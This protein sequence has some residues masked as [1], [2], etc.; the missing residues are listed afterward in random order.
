MK[1]IF[2]TTFAVAL[3]F[4]MTACVEHSIVQ[5]GKQIAFK[6]IPSMTTKAPVNGTTMPNDMPLYVSAYHNDTP[7]GE[8]YFTGV[9]FNHESTGGLWASAVPQYWPIEQNNGN[10]N[11]LAYGTKNAS[12]ITATW[13]ANVASQVVLE[14]GDNHIKR[15]DLLYS[16]ANH[17]TYSN[18]KNGVP[19]E[20]KHAHTLVVFKLMIDNENDN[21]DNTATTNTGIEI[22]SI[23]MKDIYYGGT[24]TISNDASSV[25]PLSATWVLDHKH[26]GASSVLNPA[27]ETAYVPGALKAPA[28]G[29]SY[30]ADTTP[31]GDAY[32]IFPPQVRTS[33][34]ITYT[35]HNGFDS[36]SGN[37]NN[38]ENLTYEYNC[39]DK[40]D[41]GDPDKVWEMGYKYIYE[42]NFNLHKI[43]ISPTVEKWV[44]DTSNTGV[45]AVI[46]EAQ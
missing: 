20:F 29:G 38:K 25:T 15:D 13:N 35:I 23:T 36:V 18:S 28:N 24:L 5:D 9:V 22:H 41:P 44:P 31:F 21:Y 26:T 8:N 30:D 17:R 43:T 46:V 2:L 37:A 10:L 16:S 6:P 34:T 33:F 40:V 39:N 32:A 19:M 45:N 3:F 11:F 7:S 14:V 12:N 27:T 4:L 1:K 42:I